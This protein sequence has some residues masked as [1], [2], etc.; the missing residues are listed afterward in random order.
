MRIQQR[1]LR[2]Q[3][4]QQLQEQKQQSVSRGEQAEEHRETET[5]FIDLSDDNQK[6]DL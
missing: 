3:L 1:R 2:R 5:T 4:Q 6:V